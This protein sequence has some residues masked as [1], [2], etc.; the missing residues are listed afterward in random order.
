MSAMSVSEDNHARSDNGGMMRGPTL[1]TLRFFWKFL[2]GRT[3]ELRAHFGSAS[4][5]NA[6]RRQHQSETCSTPHIPF[7][8][9]V[10][11]AV[12]RSRDH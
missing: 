11:P 1:R 5:P 12:A 7:G 6:Q 10:V 8:R 3:V 4:V 9:R 2:T